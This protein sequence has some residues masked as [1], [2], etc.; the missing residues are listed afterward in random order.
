MP[1]FEDLSEKGKS[2]VLKK[3]PDFHD[4]PEHLK[5]IIVKQ[6]LNT[7]QKVAT[8]KVRSDKKFVEKLQERSAIDSPAAAAAVSQPEA[9]STGDHGLDLEA[10]ADR[11]SNSAND[12][13][14]RSADAVHAHLDEAYRHL[15]GHHLAHAKG[16]T[17]VAAGHLI[18]ASEAVGRA[19]KALDVIKPAG[20]SA[21][22]GAIDAAQATKIAHSYTTT[23]AN[24]KFATAHIPSAESFSG[25]QSLAG[26]KGTDTRSREDKLNSAANT[27][28]K[29]AEEEVLKARRNPSPEELQARKAAGDKVVAESLAKLP[30]TPRSSDYVAV[31]KSPSERALERA[32][33]GAKRS[34]QSRFNVSDVV[35]GNTV[36]QHINIATKAI[37]EGKPIPESSHVALGREVVQGIRYDLGKA[38]QAVKSA[39]NVSGAALEDA[40]V[41]HTEEPKIPSDIEN[42]GEH[43]IRPGRGGRGGSISDFASGRG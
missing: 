8:N 22:T 42:T 38:K 19:A 14:N 31:G 35:A 2:A 20:T 3:H 34:L 5:A 39:G 7:E 37:Q 43:I 24:G 21:P 18:K 1:T 13:N 27:A 40:P 25:Q 36:A 16:Q 15:G 32:R 10:I 11:I 30:D 29:K 17:D 6:R 26:P 28:Q 23:V 33:Q 9:P 12:I 4:K 41:Q